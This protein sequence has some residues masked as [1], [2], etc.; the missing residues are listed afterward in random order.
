VLVDTGRSLS[1]GR[2]SAGPGGWHDEKG[3]PHEERERIKEWSRPLSLRRGRGDAAIWAECVAPPFLTFP[4]KEERDSD[5]GVTQSETL[6]Y[7][8][9]LVLSGS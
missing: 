8:R 2:P 4:L 9:G 6:H 7:D 3:V 1:S 5:S